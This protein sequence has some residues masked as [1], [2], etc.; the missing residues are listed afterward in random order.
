MPNHFYNNAT[1]KCIL[2][3]LLLIPYM[4]PS[5]GQQDQEKA[6][7]QKLV[8]EREARFGE[9]SR[10]AAAKSGFFGN[11]TRN[12]LR[13]QVEVLT[14]IVKTDNKIISLLKNFLDYKTF[15]RTEMVYSQAEQE[16]KNKRLDAITTRLSKE[17]E[18][19]RDQNRNLT[20]KNR[21]ARLLNWLMAV[22]TAV[23]VYYWWK[24]HRK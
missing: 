18:T 19:V 15:Q 13:N 21:W 3:S 1:M 14:E 5:Y 23:A 10:A 20:I 9:Y 6:A 12:D 8:E 17:L 24:A 4:I 2:L 22:V 11:K 16:E 7:L